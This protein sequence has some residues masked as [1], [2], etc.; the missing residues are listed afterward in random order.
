MERG[1]PSSASASSEP[2]H[3]TGDQPHS[4][5]ETTKQRGAERPAQVAAA[6]PF[7]ERGAVENHYDAASEQVSNEH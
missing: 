5:P 7:C 4:A 1:E 3:D 6:S 2:A